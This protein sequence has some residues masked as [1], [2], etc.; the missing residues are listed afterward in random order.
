MKN[1]IIFGLILLIPFVLFAQEKDATKVGIT[2]AP[3]LEIG[4]GSRAIGMGGA[5]VATANDA[6]ALYWN[7]AGVAGMR[8]GQLLLMHS[9]WLAGITFQ[10]AGVVIPLGP[11]GTIGATITSLNS[12]EMDVRTIDQPEGT[13]EIFS[14]ND[15]ALGLTYARNL[16]DRFSVGVNAKYIHQKI[17]HEKAQGFALDFGTLFNTGFHHLRIGAALTNFGTEMRLTGK[18]LLVFYDI[19]PN[20]LGNNERVPANLQTEAWPL[21]MTFQFGLATEMLKSTTQRLTIAID[22]LHPYDN[23][24]SLNLGGEYAFR[25]MIFL[26]TGYRDLFLKDGEQSWTFGLGIANRLVGTLNVSFDYAYTDFGRL[27]NSQRF[28]VLITF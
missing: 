23:T 5:F 11:V 26:R 22:A 16:T 13:G 10:F 9:Q 14:T 7:P 20:I 15:L 21:P 1:T 3:F 18:E 6:S 17:W 2:A 4:V 19:A 28:S 25:E 8:N 12:G 24:E 27:E